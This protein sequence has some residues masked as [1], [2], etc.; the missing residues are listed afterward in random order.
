M[1]RKPFNRLL[2][3]GTFIL[4][5]LLLAACGEWQPVMVNS[6][7]PQS[8]IQVDPLLSQYYEQQ[9]GAA[10]FGTVTS[11]LVNEGGKQCQFTTLGMLCYDAQAAEVTRFTFTAV[12]PITQ[13]STPFQ[14][15]LDRM[16]GTAIFGKP[17]AD[18]V[19]TSD[20]FIEQVYENVVVYSPPDNPN[21]IA[22][23]PLAKILNMTMHQPSQKKYDRRDNVIFYPVQGELGFHVPIVFDEFIARHGGTETSG[24]PISETEVVEM[25]GERAARQC[26][27]NYCLDYYPAYPAGAQVRMVQLGY[28]YEQIPQGAILVPVEEPV[29]PLAMLISEDKTQVLSSETQTFYMLVYSDRTKEPRPNVNANLVVMLP[30]GSSYFYE[31]PPTGIN[32]WTKLEIPPLTGAGHGTMVAYKICLSGESPL[33]VSETYLVWNYR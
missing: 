23:R 14:R 28:Q 27:E 16:G 18:P 11:Q 13:F 26:F 31:I 3:T 20:G 33:C 7:T 22:F 17:L 12:A 21:S 5:G 30:D 32:G 2:L 29:E 19:H 8:T 4:M 9:G 25:N 1:D 15:M 24:K 6:T 10:Q